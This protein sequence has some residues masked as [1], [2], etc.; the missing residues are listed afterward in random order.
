MEKLLVANRGEI[1]IRAFRAATQ[2]GIRT[3][4]ILPVEEERSGAL[5][6]IKADEAYV[7]GEAGRPVRAYLDHDAIVARRSR[8]GRTRSTRGTGSCP[9]APTWLKPV[10][11]PG[12]P[13]S[14]PAQRCCG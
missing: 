4:A 1:A 3:V 11:P 14:G 9:R 13:S 5:H 10:T 12:L 7:I 6:R 2:L 8:W